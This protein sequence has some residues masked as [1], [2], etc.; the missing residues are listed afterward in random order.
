MKQSLNDKLL[1]LN[2]IQGYERKE[3]KEKFLY[4]SRECV[5]CNECLL[6]HHIIEEYENIFL[7]NLKKERRHDQLYLRA[8][9]FVKIHYVSD[10]K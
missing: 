4:Y 5:G 7:R 9:E 8:F 3:L 10:P 1:R 2:T 6:R